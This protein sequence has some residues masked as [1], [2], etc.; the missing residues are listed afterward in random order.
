MLHCTRLLCQLP[1]SATLGPAVV[2]QLLQQAE[3]QGFGGCAQQ[4][5]SLIARQQ[6]SFEA[7]NTAA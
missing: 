2:A 4:L 3:I 5:R 6:Q 1:A 7:K